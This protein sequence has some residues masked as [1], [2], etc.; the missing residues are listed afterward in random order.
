MPVLFCAFF[1]LLVII[2]TFLYVN[3]GDTTKKTEEGVLLDN[4]P[5]Y[6]AKLNENMVIKNVPLILAGCKEFQEI[7]P[8]TK[9]DKIELMKLRENEDIDELIPRVQSRSMKEYNMSPLLLIL[10]HVM[11]DK[12]V[13]APAFAEGLS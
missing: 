12:K 10:G 3:F 4:K 9:A 13:N 8:E 5:Y 11:Q 7:G 6:G 1:I 2:P